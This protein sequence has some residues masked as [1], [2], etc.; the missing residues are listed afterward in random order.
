MRGGFF[1]KFAT[2]A[3][4][5]SLLNKIAITPK[6][7][8]KYVEKVFNLTELHFSDDFFQNWYFN[9]NSAATFTQLNIGDL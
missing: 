3:H 7:E 8:D 5:V 9:G 2:L 1:T 4:C 6:Y